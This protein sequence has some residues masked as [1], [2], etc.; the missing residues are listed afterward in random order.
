[1]SLFGMLACEKLQHF[2][3]SFS[4][5]ACLLDSLPVLTPAHMETLLKRRNV[6]MAIRSIARF[7][8]IS[9]SENTL[10]VLGIPRKWYGFHL[11]ACKV[12]TD[13]QNIDAS[14]ISVTLQKLAF[15]SLVKSSNVSFPPS[16][17]YSS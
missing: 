9:L 7:L 4:E 3:S 10:K 12:V 13:F 6:K 5:L 14:E 15:L 8:A 17:T 16:D 1:M 11:Q 2:P